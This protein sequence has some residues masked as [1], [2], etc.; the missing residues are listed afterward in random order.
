M[1]ILKR[2]NRRKF[3][4]RI[5]ESVWPSM[6]WGRT[7]H[8]YRHRLLRQQGSTYRIAGGLATGTAVS[9][10]PFLGTH[11]AQAVLFSWLLRVSPV[12]GFVGTGFG[13]PWTLPII[14]IVIYK[15]GVWLCGLA[16]MAGFAGFPSGL[17]MTDPAAFMVYVFDHPAKLL[18]PLA[19]GGYVCAVLS[20]PVAYA[21]LYYPVRTARRAYRLQ[22]LLRRRQRKW[23]RNQ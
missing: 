1:A 10:T 22:G 6:G 19:L 12:A 9:F 18:F 20:W 13:N 11:F 3:P 21:L 17:L 15:L 14:F 2:R 8:Y 4:K 23:D 5:R 7:W 16:G